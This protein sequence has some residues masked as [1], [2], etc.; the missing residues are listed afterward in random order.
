MSTHPT[1]KTFDD[2]LT[3]VKKDTPEVQQYLWKQI[4]FA[5]KERERLRAKD[6]RSRDKKKEEKALLPPVPRKKPG[7]KGPWKH[8]RVAPDSQENLPGPGSS[9]FSA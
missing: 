9:G 6:R 2:F 8:K 5:E 1:L 3:C 7:P 4:Q